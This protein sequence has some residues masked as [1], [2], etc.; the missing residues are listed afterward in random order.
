MLSCIFP[1]TVFVCLYMEVIC[2]KTVKYGTVFRRFLHCDTYLFL[3]DLE[4]FNTRLLISLYSVFEIL[5][6]QMLHKHGLLA[7]KQVKK[8]F[9]RSTSF[10]ASKN[11]RKSNAEECIFDYM[12]FNIERR[13]NKSSLLQ[14]YFLVILL[15]WLCMHV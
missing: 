10:P 7:I 12:A 11:C 2:P 1:Y 3:G 4:G 13:F 9:F 15:A 14:C 5:R 8:D 6:F